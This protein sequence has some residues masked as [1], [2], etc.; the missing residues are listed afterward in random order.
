MKKILTIAG[1]EYRAMVGTKAFLLSILVMPILMFGSILAMQLLKNATEV[2]TQKIVVVDRS[3]ELFD[4]LKQ[5]ADAMNAEVDARLANLDSD[6]DGGGDSED[7]FGDM[8]QVR[9]YELERW[10]S[11]S[12]T[13]DDK[14]GLSQRIRQQDLYAF[15]EIPESIMAPPEAGS[16]MDERPAIL[17][18]SEDSGFSDAKNWIGG[19]TNNFLREKRLAEN[20]IDPAVVALASQPVPV[21]GYGPVSKT[22]SGSVSQGE[23]SST[24]KAIFLPLGVMMLM[25]MVIFM[26][27][28][29]MLESVLEEKSAR[30]AEVL[31]GSANSWQLMTGKLLGTVGGSL[32]ILVVY[33]GGAIALAA[34][35]DWLEYIP[36]SLIP[37]FVIF[38][39]LGVL[40]FASIFMAVGAS[41]SQLKEAQSMLLPVWMLL[42]SPMFVWL[43]LIRDPNG[44]MATW[45][46]FFPP[47]TP[48]V[49]VLRLSTGATI[50]WW[51][52]VVASILLVAATAFCVYVAARIFRIGL[53]WQGKTPK[54][55]ELLKWAFRG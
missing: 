19:L 5:A 43:L 29:P 49:M 3:G 6:T 52:P 32:T 2:K 28:Q 22:A 18:Y 10:E 53:L 26:S 45:F 37:W 54:L 44:N 4:V 48:T 34:W 25:F 31:L 40:F 21:R 39:I 33:V 27:S 35:R 20:G 13:D 16:P 14:L 38:Q 15:V 41:V 8:D 50:P 7:D 36:V 17:F 12:F 55:N 46:S 23:E 42:M 24:A 1:R 47:A 51:Q 30:I 11:N 9:K